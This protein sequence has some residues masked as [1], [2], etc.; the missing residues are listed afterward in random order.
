MRLP[1]SMCVPLLALA[2]LAGRYDQQ[3]WCDWLG[4]HELAW[5]ADGARCTRRGCKYERTIER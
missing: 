3:T 5:Y 1:P 4:F 2:Y